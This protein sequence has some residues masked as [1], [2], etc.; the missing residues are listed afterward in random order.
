MELQY[1]RVSFSSSCGRFLA[2]QGSRP[3][4]LLSIWDWRKEEKLAEAQSPNR[5]DRGITFAKDDH[6]RLTAYG[7]KR[8]SRFYEV[9]KE[10]CSGPGHLTFWSLSRDS[11]RL[12]YLQGR[13]LLRAD[14]RGAVSS[15][16]S[17]GDGSGKVG[18]PAGLLVVVDATHF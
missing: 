13:F 4:L 12:S 6:S 2:S 15:V 7:N 16:A 18:L 14:T 1:K 8:S 3:D 10:M 5:I 17:S 11:T 9:T